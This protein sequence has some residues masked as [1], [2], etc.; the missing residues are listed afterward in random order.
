MYIGA[1]NDEPVFSVSETKFCHVTYNI[2]SCVG[3]NI[4]VYT[5]M[6][7]HKDKLISEYLFICMQTQVNHSKRLLI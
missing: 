6:L 7:Y 2:Y 3:S 5:Y 4:H 1:D